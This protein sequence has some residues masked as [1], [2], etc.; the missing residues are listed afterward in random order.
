MSWILLIQIVMVTTCT[1]GYR[2]CPPAQPPVTRQQTFAS[3]KAC[4]F[5]LAQFRQRFPERREM[6][7]SDHMVMEQQTTLRCV[8]QPRG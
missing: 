7:R 4:Q 3:E 8:P 2:F 1:E 6:V 5:A